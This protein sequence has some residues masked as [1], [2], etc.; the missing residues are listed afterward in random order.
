MK[1]LTKELEKKIEKIPI[2]SKDGQGTDAEV[3]VKFFLTG[4][5]ATWL[6][7]EGEKLDNGDYEFF[8]YVDLGYG[9][10]AG[11]FYLSQLAGLKN[12]MGLGVERE[13]YDTRKT[14][15]EYMN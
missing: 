5:A 12:R 2:Y 10:E 3:I 7:T 14:V 6:V 11:Y 15:K 13:M 4:T 9:Y 8:G 1:L